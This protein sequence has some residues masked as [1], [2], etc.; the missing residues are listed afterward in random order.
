MP[1]L[2]IR[3]RGTDDTEIDLRRRPSRPPSRSRRKTGGAAS[4]VLLI[5]FGTGTLG[6]LPAAHVNVQG[7]VV[8]PAAESLSDPAA[9][10]DL[11]SQVLADLGVDSGASLV[12]D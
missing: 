7:H 9:G 5:V 3:T 12:A 8:S 2:G 10:T 1:K 4:A 6:A 11:G